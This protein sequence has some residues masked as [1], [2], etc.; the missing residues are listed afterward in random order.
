[1]S[2]E[3]TG[4]GSALEELALGNCGNMAVPESGGGS[5]RDSEISP[6][7]R[8]RHDLLAG[9]TVGTVTRTTSLSACSGWKP[10]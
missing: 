6:G 7:A 5:W 4:G 1:M 10:A 3:I 8:A 9:V 2:P